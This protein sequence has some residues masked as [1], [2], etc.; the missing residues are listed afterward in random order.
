VS[1]PSA[2]SVAPCQVQPPN[3][4]PSRCSTSSAPATASSLRWP[5]DPGSENPLDL[6]AAQA[7][8]AGP[9]TIFPDPISLLEADQDGRELV[10]DQAPGGL[11]A[12]ESESNLAQTNEPSL[13]H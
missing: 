7:L 11:I 9:H 5:L 3:A 13:P 12:D 6:S 10:V 4:V 8:A 2:S 1:T